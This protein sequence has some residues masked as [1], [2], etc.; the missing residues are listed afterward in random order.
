MRRHLFNFLTALSLLL[1]VA[2]C[3]LWVRSYFI[4]DEFVRIRQRGLDHRIESGGGRLAWMEFDWRGIDRSFL[5]A[6]EFGAWHYLADDP[7]TSLSSL[8][9]NDPGLRARWFSVAGFAV[10]GGVPSDPVEP[11]RAVAVPHWF[12]ALVLAFG[13]GLEILH[14]LRRRTR[15]GLCPRCGY[16]MRATPDRCP[17]C[18]AQPGAAVSFSSGGKSGPC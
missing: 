10:A 1:C 16:D 14:R 5:E 13:P 2:V 7:A 15:L 8:L 18:G 12:V 4:T 6:P 3:V 17:E 11:S 9:L